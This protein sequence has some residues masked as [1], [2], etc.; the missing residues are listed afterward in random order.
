MKYFLIGESRY[1]LQARQ[2]VEIDEETANELKA[3]GYKID[4]EDNFITNMIAQ[5]GSSE[6][7][8]IVEHI[9][10]ETIATVIEITDKYGDQFELYP[11]MKEE[12]LDLN[13]A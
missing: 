9:I 2:R 3:K 11:H 7:S 13:K 4:V 8:E 12:I 5:T 1:P 10:N 6:D